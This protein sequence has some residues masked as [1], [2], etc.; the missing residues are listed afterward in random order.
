M[1]QGGC[2]FPGL[3]FAHIFYLCDF[4]LHLSSPGKAEWQMAAAEGWDVCSL[5]HI[6]QM[7][8]DSCIPIPQPSSCDATYA[9]RDLVGKHIVKLLGNMLIYSLLH[10]LKVLYHGP[11]AAL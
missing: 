1:Q 3:I 4:E 8:I 9:F 6:F 10:V 2:C 7:L 5:C 11:T